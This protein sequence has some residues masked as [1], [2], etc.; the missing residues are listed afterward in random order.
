MS[1]WWFGIDQLELRRDTSRESRQYTMPV[2]V[3]GESRRPPL[4]M[5]RNLNRKYRPGHDHRDRTRRARCSSSVTGS[6]RHRSRAPCSYVRRAV[7]SA[8]TEPVIH[9]D[10]RRAHRRSTSARRCGRRPA[11]VIPKNSFMASSERDEDQCP[12]RLG[13]M[14]VEHQRGGSAPRRRRRENA[15]R[16]CRVPRGR[17]LTT[18]PRIRQA[19]RT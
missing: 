11:S 12:R 6:S 5:S 13:P 15:V 19:V 7:R 9:R 18:R 2:M 3:D 1:P 16:G 17:Q 10:G 8:A 4:D 14:I